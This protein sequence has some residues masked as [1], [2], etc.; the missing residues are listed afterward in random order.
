MKG[1]VDVISLWHPRQTGFVSCRGP[2]TIGLSFRISSP[3]SKS[4]VAIR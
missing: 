2:I 3:S 4:F 1:V